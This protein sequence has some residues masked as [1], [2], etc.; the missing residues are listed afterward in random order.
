MDVLKDQNGGAAQKAG[1]KIEKKR[2]DHLAQLVRGDVR[3]LSG[4]GSRTFENVG[5]KR[6]GRGDG[7]I[8]RKKIS[9]QTVSPLS[10]RETLVEPHLPPEKAD[11]GRPG[12]LPVEAFTRVETNLSSLRR[13]FHATGQICGQGRLS[14]P[15]LP[16][17][18]DDAEPSVPGFLPLVPEELLLL[19][20]SGQGDRRKGGRLFF[21][22][23]PVKDAR[24]RSRNRV[25]GE[26]DP[27]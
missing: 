2:L 27:F 26:G 19:L 25:C 5:K 23:N 7:G 6:E 14:H 12:S 24:V 17:D 21:R 10:G 20:S 11:E 15:C 1:G 3:H 13:E 22:E 4:V 9:L 8:E 16:R 18:P